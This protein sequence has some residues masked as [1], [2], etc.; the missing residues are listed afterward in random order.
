MKRL[1]IVAGLSGLGI[2]ILAA[3]RGLW[4]PLPD[5][6]PARLADVL[7]QTIRSKG[8]DAAVAQYR[9]LRG[10]G[11]P[12]L[13]ESN[14]ET[15]SL[16]YEL[17]KKG[18]TDSAIQVFRLNVETH[19]RSANA[20]DS[21]GEAYA[22]ADQKECAVASYRRSLELNPNSASGADALRKLG[23]GS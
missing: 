23:G 3:T 2:C 14:A 9:T 1:H 18:E 17:L 12:G 16:G 15:N 20:H 11:F 21:L 4:L 13:H 22:A 6:E 10:Q 19:P 5:Q 7:S 8:I